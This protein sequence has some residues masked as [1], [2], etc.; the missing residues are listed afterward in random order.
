MKPVRIK[1]KEI[2]VNQ[3]VMARHCLHAVLA[4]QD[5]LKRAVQE[6]SKERTVVTV[7]G[8]AVHRLMAGRQK[9]KVINH[10]QSETPQLPAEELATIVEKAE[11]IADRVK[12]RLSQGE[13]LKVE[14][15]MSWTD[16][17]T[18][19]KIFAQPDRVEKFTDEKGE[20]IAIRDLKFPKRV[21]ERHKEAARIFGLVMF[22][23][24]KGDPNTRIQ[25]IVEC[26]QEDHA[27]EE[28]LGPVG[29]ILDELN[30]VQDTLRR[31][32][33]AAAAAENGKVVPRSHGNHCFGCKLREQCKQGMK[34]IAREKAAI[35]DARAARAA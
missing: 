12:A 7:L 30:S 4:S 3:L 9:D 19:W 8:D 32:D 18:G 16:V 21:R 10:L 22:M 33:A 24:L 27:W 34:Y 26:L 29:M 11:R 28:W 2:A 5:V 1:E 25:L 35:A 23:K 17:E 31:I 15:V 6:G 14:D 13:D 20:F